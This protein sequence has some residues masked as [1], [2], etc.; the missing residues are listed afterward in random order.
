M[1]FDIPQLK[2]AFAKRYPKLINVYNWWN[3]LI[4]IKY[5]KNHFEVDK[6]SMKQKLRKT[7][8]Y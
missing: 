7:R 1:S 3:K 5:K 8:I 4:N 2:I 6:L